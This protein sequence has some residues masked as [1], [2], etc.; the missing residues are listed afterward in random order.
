MILDKGLPSEW[1]GEES[2]LSS[3]ATS[4]YPFLPPFFSN[5][6]KSIQ[7]SPSTSEKDKNVKPTLHSDEKLPSDDTSRKPGKQDEEEERQRHSLRGKA[8]PGQKKE[9]LLSTTRKE[10]AHVRGEAVVY[11]DQGKEPGVF[12]N[13]APSQ[14]S[15]RE[16]PGAEKASG[17]EGIRVEEIYIVQRGEE[18]EQEE[19]K[20]S[21]EEEGER[22]REKLKIFYKTKDSSS[23]RGRLAVVLHQDEDLYSKFLNGEDWFPPSIYEKCTGRKASF[24]IRQALLTH[25]TYAV[26]GRS[27]STACIS[28]HTEVALYKERN[29]SLS[30]PR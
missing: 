19:R 2:G 13:G 11:T 6:E 30:L 10:G 26:R 3:S 23:D 20:G 16:I 28:R 1:R 25:L 29:P 17:M 8:D 14:G 18:E 7:S 5:Q 24:N 4:F 21:K 15:N 12:F 22:R 9:G 27:S